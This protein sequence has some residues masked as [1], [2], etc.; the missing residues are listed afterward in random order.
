M[1]FFEDLV[2]LYAGMIHSPRLGL[3]STS[4]LII[5]SKTIYVTQ[6]NTLAAQSLGIENYTGNLICKLCLKLSGAPSLV[7]VSLP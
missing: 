6:F 1:F 3:I 2:E 5:Y 7:K 4:G